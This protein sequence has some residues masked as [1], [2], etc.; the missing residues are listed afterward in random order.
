[1]PARKQTKIQNVPIKKTQTKKKK[2]YLPKQ[3]AAILFKYP[4]LLGIKVIYTDI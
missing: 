4:G 3:R 1:M 2:N